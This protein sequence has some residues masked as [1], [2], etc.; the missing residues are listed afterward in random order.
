VTAS[1]N[2]ALLKL[3]LVTSALWT[4]VDNDGWM[5]L[6]VVG[7][8][9]PVTYFK[10]KGGKKFEK[11]NTPSL[12]HSTGWWNSITA[13]DFDKDGD[14]DYIVGNLG[15]NT[16]YKGTEK[17]PLCVNARDYDKNGSIDP[18]LSMYINHEKQVAHSWDDMVKQMTPIR[19]RF[20]T[21]DP[22]AK[23]TFENSFLPEEI[24][25]S[26]QVCGEWFETSY[27]E[28]KGN[29]NLV[30]TPLAKQLQFSPE[31]GTVVED[32]NGD[33]NL[34]ALLVGNSY[35][36]EVSTGRYDASIGSYLQGDGKGKFALVPVTTSGFC[37]DQDAK[38][39]AR[40]V[41]ADG[42][43]LILATI[44][45]GKMKVFHSNR[46]NKYFTPA[47]DDAYAI[48]QLKNGTKYKHEFYFGSTYL[49]NSSR[50]LV[51]SNNMKE[52]AVYRFTGEKRIVTP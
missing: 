31:Y 14:M 50:K 20:R 8:F 19:A 29:G 13:G 40:L 48:I 28:N 26:Y 25:A 16:R 3:G 33:G 9:M 23:A 36:T 18:V 22:Y 1:V 6:L 47:L 41:L 44:N 37:V 15:L 43:E 7:E 17:E 46:S 27:L 49:S 24:A 5:D 10:N 30:L 52:I 45:N 42:S 39:L 51:L 4:D 32:L 11:I 38:G 12:S 21:Y 35:A 34:D 2:P